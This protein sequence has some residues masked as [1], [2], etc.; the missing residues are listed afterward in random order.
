MFYFLLFSW[1]YFYRQ[2]NSAT[3]TATAHNIEEEMNNKEMKIAEEKEREKR[4]NDRRKEAEMIRQKER[5]K[6]RDSEKEALNELLESVQDL[7]YALQGAELKIGKQICKIVMTNCAVFF[8]SFF[9]LLSLI[10]LIA[11]LAICLLST[12]VH[13]GSLTN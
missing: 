10:F 6:E 9:L 2:I 5:E 4:E 11:R 1:I 7:H 3:L 13:L 12:C 8:F